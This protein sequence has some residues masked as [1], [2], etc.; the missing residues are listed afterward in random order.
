MK[1]LNTLLAI[2]LTGLAYTT[3]ATAAL[4]SDSTIGFSAEIPDHWQISTPTV[5]FRS[6][7]HPSIATISVGVYQ[8]D[9][10][11]TPGM[12]EKIRTTAQFDGWINLF[13]RPITA[14]ENK[15]ANAS[16][17]KIVAYGMNRIR[18]SNRI[19]KRVV[20]EYYYIR[21]AQAY[22]VSLETTEPLWETIQPQFKS[23]IN[24]F[25]LT[26]IK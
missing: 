19:E 11:P 6:F 21:P 22:F 25:I 2:I 9:S 5:T 12:V 18:E 16:S 10:T 4:I 14:T 24:T 23:F 1:I 7:I 26:T 3:P 8:F 20:I 13:N 17:G 15:L